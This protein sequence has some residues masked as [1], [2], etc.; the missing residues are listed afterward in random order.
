LEFLKEVKYTF[1][2]WEVNESHQCLAFPST[3]VCIAD[4]P[5]STNVLREW[6]RD[7]NISRLPWARAAH[8]FE[9][10]LRFTENLSIQR[11]FMQ[12]CPSVVYL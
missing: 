4:D 12:F 9:A 6:V 1:V 2:L 8:N 5:L 7:K 11:G 3:F 10:F